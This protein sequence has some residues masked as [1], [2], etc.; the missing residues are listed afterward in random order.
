MEQDTTKSK[1]PDVKIRNELN[2]TKSFVSVKIKWKT[3]C[4]NDAIRDGIIPIIDNC[5]KIIYNSFHLANIHFLKHLENN[6]DLPTLNQSYFQKLCTSVSCMYDKKIKNLMILK[7]LT[8]SIKIV[9]Q[10]IIKCHQKII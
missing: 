8:M 3:F 6:D 5:N 4:K 7:I 1:R 9:I 10:M 2:K